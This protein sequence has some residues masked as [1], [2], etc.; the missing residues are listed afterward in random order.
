MHLIYF[1]LFPWVICVTQATLACRINYL[2]K[3]ARSVLVTVPWVRRKGRE[4]NRK[5]SSLLRFK[6]LGYFNSKRKEPMS[7]KDGA[8]I[9]PIRIL[10]CLWTRSGLILFPIFKLHEINYLCK[11]VV[12]I[13][14]QPLT[15]EVK[16]WFGIHYWC[17]QLFQWKTPSDSLGAGSGRH[18]PW[19]LARMPR[20]RARS[21]RDKCWGRR[22]GQDKAG[23]TSRVA[24]P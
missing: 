23:F 10:S 3:K 9:K 1:A 6:L 11:P 4:Q 2:L 24:G 21:F 22:G 19:P 8:I 7:A 18:T 15:P 5:N 12:R 13:V 20:A 14:C 16:K 17:E